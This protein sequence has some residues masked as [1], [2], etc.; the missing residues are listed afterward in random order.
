MTAAAEKPTPRSL[1]SATDRH[2][3][4]VAANLKAKTQFADKYEGASIRLKTTLHNRP[5]IRSFKRIFNTG[6]RNWYIATSVPRASLGDSSLAAQVEAGMLKKVGETIAH[7]RQKVSQCDVVARDA[8][9]DFSLI[10]HGAE[11][12]DDTRVIGPV[13]MQLRE[14]FLLSDKYLDLM[15]ALYAFEQ[16]TGDDANNASFDVKK[17]LEAVATSIRNFRRMALEKVNDS[18]KNRQGFKAIVLDEEAGQAEI[19]ALVAPAGPQSNVLEISSA[20]V[21]ALPAADHVAAEP[22]TGAAEAEAPAVEPK[23]SRK[24]A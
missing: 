1:P 7:F 22:A 9:V 10:S 21:V 17:R 19:A 20:N 4:L 14:L 23:K 13:A 24:T 5:V 18:G 6:M 12:A 15:Q 2:A 3:T 16:A 11:F 8:D